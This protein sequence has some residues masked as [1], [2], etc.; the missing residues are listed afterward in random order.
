[1][2]FQCLLGVGQSKP[3]VQ[4]L[5]IPPYSMPRVDLSTLINNPFY[6]LLFCFLVLHPICLYSRPRL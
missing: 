1:M 6:L 3:L 4:E 2:D 5:C